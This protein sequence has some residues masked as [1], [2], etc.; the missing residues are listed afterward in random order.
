MRLMAEVGKLLLLGEGEGDTALELSIP[1]QF[2]Q[3]YNSVVRC[4]EHKTPDQGYN[5]RALLQADHVCT[6]TRRLQYAG[7]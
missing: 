4:A 5:A 1:F 2:I 6:N 7:N 3:E